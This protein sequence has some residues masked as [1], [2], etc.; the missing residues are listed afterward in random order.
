MSIQYRQFAEKLIYE[1]AQAKDIS[2]VDAAWILR[3][4]EQDKRILTGFYGLE[5]WSE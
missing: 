3:D 2:L 4:Y 1:V 5:K